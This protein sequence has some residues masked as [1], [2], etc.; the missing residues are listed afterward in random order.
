MQ[1][2]VAHP[3]E[4]DDPFSDEDPEETENNE[5]CINSDQGEEDNDGGSSTD[6][7]S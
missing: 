2:F 3:D 5:I 4:I 7:Q 1:H 6:D